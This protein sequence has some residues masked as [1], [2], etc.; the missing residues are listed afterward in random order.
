MKIA[1]ETEIEKLLTRTITQ[2]GNPS[3]VYEVLV[4]RECADLEEFFPGAAQRYSFEKTRVLAY[5]GE[6][7][8]CSMSTWYEARH[9]E[10]SDDTQFP[11]AIAFS[12][13]HLKIL[14]PQILTLMSSILC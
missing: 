12:L 1:D 10:L 14:L 2:P 13:G 3:S 5:H 9:E 7:K 4:S 8:L 6:M 11:L